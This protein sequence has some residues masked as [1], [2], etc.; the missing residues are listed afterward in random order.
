MATPA[1][2]A[3]GLPSAL[4]R[5]L[6]C[7]PNGE[8]RYQ[9]LVIV[10]AAVA[11]GILAD[12]FR[13]L[14][15][16]M[17][18]CFAIAGLGTW[19]AI[20]RRRRLLW[21][22]L[23]VLLAVAATAAAWHHCR[24]N[25]FAVNNFGRYARCKAQPVCVE[26]VA[27]ESPRP[28]AAPASNPM[29]PI[30]QDKVSR[31]EVELVALR[32]GDSWQPVSGRAMLTVHDPPPK[33]A[34]HNP[35]PEIAA[36][37]RLRVFGRL[38]APSP[39]QNPG[40]PDYAARLRADGVFGR[41]VAEAPEC[42]SI[43]RQG[44]SLSLSRLLDRLRVH[45]NR[46]LEKYLDPRHAALSEA[47]LLGERNRVEPERIESFMVVGAIHL[48]VI[49]GLHIGILAGALFW[50]IRR[51]SLSRGWAA[52][53]VATTIVAY[54][55]LVD[56]GPPVVRATILVLDLCAAEYLGRRVLSFNALAAAAL[57]V[58]AINP[59]NLFHAGAQ[60]SF[61]SVAAI[62]RFAPQWFTRRHD[63]LEKL[64]ERNR[65]WHERIYWGLWRSVRH[66]TLVSLTI[67]LLTMPL[68]MARFHLCSPVAVLLNTVL[69]IPMACSLLGSFFLLILG[70]LIPPLADV[71]GSFCNLTLAMLEGCVAAARRVPYGHFWVA[72]PADWWL[73]G[74]YGALMLWAAFPRLRPAR[75][76]CVAMLAAWI[77][78][79][80]TAAAWSRHHDRLDCT[81][82]SVG[83]GC[84]A[85]VE[86][87]SGQ[88]LLYD[89][90]QMGEPAIGER[91]IADFLWWRGIRRLDAVALSHADLDHYNALPG[92]LEK[93]SVGA[94]Y[95][96]PVM[97]EKHNPAVAALRAAIDRSGTPLGNLQAGDRLL[98]GVGCTMEVLHP[99]PGGVMGSENANSLV[100]A[101]EYRGRRI[102]LPGDLE[103]PGLDAM[104]REEPMRCD[105]LLAPHHGSRKSNSPALAAWCRPRW[106]IFSG[107]GRWN[108]PEGESP[109]RAVGGQVLGT[110][111]RGAIRVRIN[112][113]GVD[114]SAFVEPRRGGPARK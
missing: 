32:N 86:L 9:P 2:H 96:S 106:V 51:W 1:T 104:L 53:I 73:A 46:L 50:I 35:L 64:V 85:V 113:G 21:E 45:S 67:W 114:V 110:F 72:G 42:V 56:A 13:P 57:V 55:L 23:A 65:Y 10:L 98:G 59:S 101:V 3:N 105:V 97:F 79:G 91:T 36:G 41:L 22:N 27:V 54:M 25:L 6:N 60:L 40:S 94:V 33:I 34:A 17:W 12:R 30:P 90:G 38:S 61:L 74:F 66:L 95:V 47:I 109:Y 81:F 92:L 111:D 78:V 75:R 7:R 11:A 108:V 68:V 31:L 37:D 44:G 88:T 29:R 63:P 5:Q 4:G 71:L 52:G 20:R 16:G 102:L 103:P 76:R 84:A 112:A 70:G 83:H 62:M 18:W 28:V 89:A 80:F 19:P 15:V 24:W 48:L 58:L 82:L 43:V 100:L 49:A 39:P 99:P 14:P 8:P 107:D 93:F 77:A 87:P 69:W 26:G